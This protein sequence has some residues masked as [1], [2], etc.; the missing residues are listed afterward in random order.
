[1]GIQ[2]KIRSAPD[3]SGV[4]LIRDAHGKIIYVGKANSLR[5]RLSSYL[6][7]KL[8]GKAIAMMGAARDI[9]W[10]LVPTEAM[11]LLLEASL[12]REYRP[13]Y[14]ISLR[15]DKSFPYVKMTNE[16]FPCIYVT[17]KKENDGARYFGP[18]T[19]AGLLREALKIIRKTFPYR[20]CRN[21]PNRPCIYYRL[22]LSPA[23][24]AGKISR[25]AYRETLSNIAMLLDGKTESLVKELAG[26]M[27]KMAEKREYEE[28]ARIRDQINTLSS[29]SSSQA[30]PSGLNELEDIKSRLGLKHL[31]LRIEAFDISNIQGQEAVGSMVSFYKAVSDKNNYRR[32]KI[33]TVR[34]IDDYKMMAEVV[35]RRYSRM[36]EDKL[37]MPDLILIDGGKAHLCVAKRELDK[38][39]LKIPV[40]SIA[41]KEENIYTSGM[42]LKRISEGAAALNLIRRIRD[43]AHRFALSYHHLLR[44]K[45][46]I[47]A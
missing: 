18:Y 11:A 32:F 17:R 38:L 35:S 9:E 25:K 16:D 13:K 27:H 5:K 2:E 23:P 30:N 31:P 19:S 8:D 41:K 15:D 37:P 3:A 1:L 39:K 46:L 47:D 42:R 7:R 36:I 10:R 45:K 44:R 6:G 22:N 12:I 28:A 43:E 29:I 4:Y 14:N 24:C 20:S 40:I 33:K 21:M 26:N 34:G